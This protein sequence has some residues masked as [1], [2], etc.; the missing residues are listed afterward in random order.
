MAAKKSATRR[1]QS[2]STAGKRAQKMPKPGPIPDLIYAQAS[3]CSQGG[4]SMFDAGAQIN[5]RTVANFASEGD[6]VMRAAASLEAAGFRVLQISPTTINI[7]GSRKTF[8]QAFGT[9]I[10]AEERPVIK[11]EGPSTAWTAVPT[12]T[13]WGSS[14]TRP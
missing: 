9:K 3:P 4:V 6:L 11:P 2:L 10:V 14:S 13:G 8:E 12:S 1:A 7:A 5:S